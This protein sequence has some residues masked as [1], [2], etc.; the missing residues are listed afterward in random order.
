MR[1]DIKSK[2]EKALAEKEKAKQALQEKDAELT[3]I[4]KEYEVI[5]GRNYLKAADDFMKELSG[6]QL[7]KKF[8]KAVSQVSEL[9]ELNKNY[10]TELSKAQPYG[11]DPSPEQQ[12]L[13][14]Y[15]LHTLKPTA[16][17]A[18]VLSKMITNKKV[19]GCP[20]HEK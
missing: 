13:I 7:V 3:A 20:F 18:A 14:G 16:N 11:V 8:N 6:G 10:Q 12:Y 9:A 4:E 5:V 15:L 17:L 1:N 2:R 19:V